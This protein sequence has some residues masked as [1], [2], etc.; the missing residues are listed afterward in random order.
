M[1]DFQQEP[2]VTDDNVSASAT[3]EN[4]EGFEQGQSE[5]STSE[6]PEATE[7]KVSFDPRQQEKVNELIGGKVAKIY[8]AT[9]RA[10]DAERRLAELQQ[11]QPVETAPEIP[12]APNP[13][14][15]YDN[16]EGYAAK[17]KERDEAI[18]KRAELDALAKRSQEEQQAQAQR[19]A[20]EVHQKQQKQIEGYTQRATSFGISGDQ[21]QQ[22][23]NL[24]AQS[25]PRDLA[26]FIVDDAQGP[27]IANYLSKNILALDEVRGM[28]PLNAVAYIER[29]VRPKLASTRKTTSAPRPAEVVEGN[30]PE[31][32]SPL[33]KGAKFE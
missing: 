30:A 18:A 3:D 11:Q 26:E 27:L 24:V 17:I 5:S 15:F 6:N 1:D 4:A 16:P 13:D 8:E 32:R 28:S 33:I 31:T 29:E 23:A 21:M 10:E 19:Q 22:D 9:R 12:P 7:E 20:L 14:D 2:V 25:V